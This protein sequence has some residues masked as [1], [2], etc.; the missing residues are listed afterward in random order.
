MIPSVVPSE[1]SGLT[2]LEEML[3]AKALPI[4]KAVL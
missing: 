4:I 3:V 2:Q 1:L